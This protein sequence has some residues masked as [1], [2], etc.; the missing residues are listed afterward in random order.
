MDIK[1]QIDQDIKHAMLAGDKTLVTTLRGV[2]SAI[3]Y[4]EVAAGARDKGLT[5]EAIM[6]VLGKEAKKRQESVDM[7]RQGGSEVRA[8]AEAAEKSVIEKYLPAQMSDDELERLVTA[9]I[10]ELDTSGPQAMGPVIAEVKRRSGGQ[11]DGGRI[12]RIAKEK[13]Q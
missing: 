6:A 10:T 3:L 4:A 12:A 13:L 5:E 11:A 9:V 1:A 2:K 7:Y 8:Q